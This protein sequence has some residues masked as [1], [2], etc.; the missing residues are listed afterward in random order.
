M[1]LIQQAIGLEVQKRYQ[2]IREVDD[3]LIAF[4]SGNFL[5]HNVLYKNEYQD[6]SKWNNYYAVEDYPYFIKT[7][8]SDYSL[9]LI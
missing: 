9:I 4:Y 7:D 6:F 1:F 2:E 3:N 5:T 8:L